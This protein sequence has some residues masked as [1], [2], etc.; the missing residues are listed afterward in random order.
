[1][2]SREGSNTGGIIIK[3]TVLGLVQ[4]K[5]DVCGDFRERCGELTALDLR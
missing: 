1:M 3:I 5:H 2:I 4:T